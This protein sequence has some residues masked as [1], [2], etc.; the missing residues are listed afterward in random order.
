MFLFIFTLN[1]LMYSINIAI[2]IISYS[3]VCR[4]AIL[5][6]EFCTDCTDKL[7]FP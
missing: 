5:L 6:A 1:F 3:T 4:L 7:S 2:T